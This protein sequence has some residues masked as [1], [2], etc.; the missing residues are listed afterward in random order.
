M[1]I[2]LV[3]SPGCGKTTLAKAF[4]DLGV[5]TCFESVLKN[6]YLEKSY[7]DPEY[8]FPAQL[9]FALMKF[10]DLEKN[11]D[12]PLTVYDQGMATSYA[13]NWAIPEMTAMRCANN[14]FYALERKFGKADHIIF[15]KCSPEI[16]LSRIATRGRGFETVSKEWL[17]QMTKAISEEFGGYENSSILTTINTDGWTFDS[18]ANFAFE[19]L[20]KHRLDTLCNLAKKVV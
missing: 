18:Y 13:F 2:E 1:R 11:K 3:G 15:V 12:A 14:S 5:N 16:Q 17:E 20:L 10:D 4:M 7:S 6:P 9:Q 19:Y 8:R